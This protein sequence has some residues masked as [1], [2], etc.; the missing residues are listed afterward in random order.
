[1]NLFKS[2]YADN[3]TL[4][5]FAWYATLTTLESFSS[6]IILKIELSVVLYE[7]NTFVVWNPLVFLFNW[8]GIAS[9]SI[10]NLPVESIFLKSSSYK[11]RISLFTISTFLKLFV[12]MYSLTDCGILPTSI[13]KRKSRINFRF[14][15]SPKFFLL[16]NTLFNNFIV[17]LSFKAQRNSSKSIGCICSFLSSLG[18][19]ISFT[20]FL[21]E[22]NEPVSI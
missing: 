5:L 12:V 4:G 14:S 8:D 18:M 2:L 6:E 9:K 10:A 15:L 3:P 17:E 1:L 11:F 19:R 13:Y 22:I 21:I 16:S 7:F 20:F